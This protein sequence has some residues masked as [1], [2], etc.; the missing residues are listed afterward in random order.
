MI[1]LSK[2]SGT[3]PPALAEQERICLRARQRAWAAKR[4]AKRNEQRLIEP[5]GLTLEDRARAARARQRKA[6]RQVAP[7]R[8]RLTAHLFSDPWESV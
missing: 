4:R 1:D 8:R 3:S 7:M 5:P 2:T 6:R